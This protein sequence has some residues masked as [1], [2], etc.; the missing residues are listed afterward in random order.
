MQI[1]QLAVLVAASLVSAPLF[2]QEPV[3]Q[4][5]MEGTTG[6]AQDVM[7]P[8]AQRNADQ[9]VERMS[10]FTKNSQAFKDPYVFTHWMN[11]MTDP[12]MV[13]ALGDAAVEP[14]NWLHMMTTML[15][16][17]AVSNY[18]QFMIDPMIYARWAGA[19]VDPMWYTKLATDMSN[20]AKIMG[21]MMLPLDRRLMQT[22][23]KPLDP[24][25]YLKFMMM[26]TD[27]RGMALMFAPMNPQL[28]GSMMG[29]LVN[30]QLVGG[31]NSTWGTFM[32][33][34][35]SVVANQP[36]APLTLPINLLDPSSYANVL[37]IIPGMPS[38]NG[39]QGGAAQGAT[40]PFNMLPTLPGLPS[41]LP[42]AGQ[43]AALNPAPLG[44]SAAVNPFLAMQ[45]AAPAGFAVQ[46]GAAST[47]SIG[48]DELFKTG[49]SSVKNLTAAGRAKLD[50]LVAKIK[51]YGEIDSVKVTGHADKMGKPAYNQKLSLARAKAVASYLKSKGVKAKS[52]TMVGMGD[53][54]PVID[55]DMTLAKDALK[56]CLA[57]NRRVDIEVTG[58]KK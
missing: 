19:M 22:S 6:M 46:S 52:F 45:Q 50:D 36:T 13:A 18:A 44:G 41:G 39:G 8:P 14:G 23:L 4:P 27:P 33:P 28:Y 16:P 34:R 47:L 25:M 49:K 17:A 9:W 37:N 54:K 10:D 5:M 11:A 24:N 3:A 15:Q 56:T 51:A 12:T 55:C 29:A 48:G 2:A 31:A 35:Q 32:Y 30:P 58:A 1:K 40:F 7:P 20:P 21:W 43:P 38:L 57:P 42:S 53:T 26:P